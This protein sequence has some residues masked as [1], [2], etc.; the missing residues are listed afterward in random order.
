MHGFIALK[1]GDQTALQAG[2]L[3]LNPIPHI[4]PLGSILLPVLMFVSTAGQFALGWAKPVPVN[5]LNFSNIR[6]GELFVSMAG[7]LANLFLAIL[8]AVFFRIGVSMDFN[9]ILLSALVFGVHINLALAFFNLIPVPP[10]DGSKMLLSQ[11]PYNLARSYERL[12]PYGFFILLALMF[13]GVVNF[14][15]SQVVSPITRLMLGI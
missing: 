9:H 11:L 4:D 15:F 8:S 5:P 14:L 6:T 10:L 7:I 12:T 13:F 2:R 1:F 3:T